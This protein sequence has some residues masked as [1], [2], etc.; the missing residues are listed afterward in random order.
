MIYL[1]GPKGLGDAIMLRAIVLHLKEKEEI[2]VFTKWTDV[3][4]GLNIFIKPLSELEQYPNMLY[5]STNGR[6]EIPEG[7]SDFM[8]RCKRAGISESVEFKM[9]WVVQNHD[10]VERIRNEANGRKIFVY[11]PLKIARNEQQKILR[12]D[13]VA[14]RQFIEEH[15]D[16]YRI[17]LGHPPYVDSNNDLPCELDLFGK[18]FIKDSFDVGTTGDIFF[19]ESCFVIQMGEALNKSCILMRSVRAMRED[20]WL[21][22]YH[23]PK[24]VFTKKHLAT[25][26][27]DEHG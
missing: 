5:A 25:T 23:D 3:F 10:L 15:S 4:H 6:Q 13:M 1:N 2:T 16:C 27:Y 19:G 14:Y 7:S 20:S 8:E 11:Q 9:D 18:A 22:R 26:V 24:R 21:N 12:P 17:K